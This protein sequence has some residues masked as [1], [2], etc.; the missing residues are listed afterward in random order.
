V[1]IEIVARQFC[2]VIGLN[3]ALSGRCGPSRWH[4]RTSSGRR[5]PAPLE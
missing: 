1:T 5:L 3:V 4:H 2:H